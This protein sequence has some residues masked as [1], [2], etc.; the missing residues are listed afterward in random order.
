MTELA[1]KKTERMENSTPYQLIIVKTAMT[2]EDYV[3]INQIL[4]QI[5]G[6][7][8]TPNIYKI[9]AT[10]S[11]VIIKYLEKEK[12]NYEIYTKNE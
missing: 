11:K 10:K 12:I 7:K 3:K 5:Q 4:K 6:E 8:R 9:P 1:K 2:G